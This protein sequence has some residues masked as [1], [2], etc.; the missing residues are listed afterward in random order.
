MS[1]KI[2]PVLKLE[3]EVKTEIVQNMTNEQ[4]WPRMAFKVFF[5]TLNLEQ[6]RGDPIINSPTENVFYTL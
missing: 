5:L 6:G 1:F 2:K 4:K 3:I